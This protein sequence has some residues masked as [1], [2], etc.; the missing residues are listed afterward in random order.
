MQPLID[1]SSLSHNRFDKR[2]VAVRARRVNTVVF[3]QLHGVV[4]DAACADSFHE[5]A[6][7]EQLVVFSDLRKSLD[8][9]DE[10]ILVGKRHVKVACISSEIGNYDLAFGFK[11]QQGREYLRIVAAPVFSHQ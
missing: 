10:P 3:G 4:I 11:N 6:T 2:V 1:R 5:Q 8:A 9:Y 7:V